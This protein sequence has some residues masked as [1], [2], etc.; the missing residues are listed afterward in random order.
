MSV[1]TLAAATAPGA[2]PAGWGVRRAVRLAFPEPAPPAPDPER[3]ERLRVYLTDLLRPYG[4]ALGS[5]PP[6][7]GGR[8]YGDL[9][10]ELIRRAVPAGEQ[11]D[12]LVLA[13]A[14]PDV[15]PGRATATWLS[16]VC[17]GS[18][19]AFAVADQGPAAAFTA[20]RLIHAYATTAAL[21]RALLLVVEQPALPYAPLT[22]PGPGGTVAAAYPPPE[23]AAADGSPAPPTPDARA[24]VPGPPLLPDAAYGVALLLG[25]PA[26][27]EQPAG[28]GALRTGDATAADVHDALGAVA[29][30]AVAVLGPGLGARDLGA[31]TRLRHAA[32][33]RPGTGVWWE[34][35][36]ALA[37]PSP[38][39][40][41]LVLA[42][43]A[44]ASEGLALAALDLPPVTTREPAGATR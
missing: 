30:D 3:T 39:P 44:P 25:P 17:P 33:T 8:A 22:S 26:P 27:G 5:E 4:L 14:V 23:P 15:T 11:V 13:Y 6:D 40:R 31:G 7:R 2:A 35:A 21:P 20:L 24:A 9:A 28:L 36:D 18:P 42:D 12:L 32:A 41:R 16:H 43:R 38:A 19:L 10:A 37:Q 34:L 1:R 29:G